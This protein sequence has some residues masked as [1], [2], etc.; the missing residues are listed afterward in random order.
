M[1]NNELDY[2]I[3]EYD[4][5]KEESTFPGKK[6]DSEEDA[7]KQAINERFSDDWPIP[8]FQMTEGQLV[9]PGTLNSQNQEQDGYSGEQRLGNMLVSE[10]EY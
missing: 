3:D 8:A 9:L 4:E 7:S 10:A 1:I 5:D 2:E 6:V